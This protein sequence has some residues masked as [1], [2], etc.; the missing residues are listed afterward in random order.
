MASRKDLPSVDRVLGGNGVDALADGY[1]LLSVKDAVRDLQQELRKSAE[2]PAW[3]TNP[4]AYAEALHARLNA[5]V[6]AGLTPVFNVTGTIIHTNLGRAL[7]S[8]A[9]AEAGLRAATQ[10]V[11]LEYDLDAGE[12]GDRDALVT[13]M[14]C[15]LTGAEAATV[16]NNN[17]AAVLLALNSLAL[18][19]EVAVSRGELIEIGGSFRMPDIMSRAGCRL[20]EVGTTNRTH[21]R[22]F[23]AAVNPDTAALLRVHPSNYHIEGFTRM[24][25]HRE[26]ADL[27]HAHNLPLIVDLGSGA[28]VDLS[29]YGLPHEPTVRET[30]NQGADI[31]TFSGDKLLGSVQAGLIVGRR[32]LVEALKRNPMKRALR[33]DKI[34]LGILHYTLK[35]YQDPERLSEEL[36]L[37]RTLTRPITELNALAQRIAAY[38][39]PRL[40]SACR[41]EVAK[42]D[43]QIG[44]GALPDQQLASA[45]VQITATSDEVLRTLQAHLRHLPIPVIARLYDGALLMDV[46]TIDD[47]TTFIN[48]LDRLEGMA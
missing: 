12:R 4:N 17:A 24:V 18:D 3:A 45:A 25:G 36:P 40:G 43:S 28:L 7:I 2:V 8:E 29:R 39:T 14:L 41:I 32:E 1:G 34:T 46:R 16:V 15:A 30:L 6:G 44:S 19:R 23:E 35:L 22:D 20:H 31:V 47:E 5:A 27:A 48:N 9:M 13:N 42:T 33:P 37:L 10:A 38:L 11:T 26:L 21:P